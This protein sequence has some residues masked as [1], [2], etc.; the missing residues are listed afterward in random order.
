MAGVGKLRQLVLYRLDH[1]GVAVAGVE[2]RDAGRKV[3][4]ATP[5][6]IPDFGIES[7]SGKIRA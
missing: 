4:K 3:D 2:N 6:H 5:F 1:R 7:A